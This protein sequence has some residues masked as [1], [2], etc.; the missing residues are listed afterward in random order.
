MKVRDVMTTPVVTVREEATLEEVARLMLERNIGGIPVVKADG[1]LAGIVTESDFSAKK[2]PVPFSLL[3][4]PS[5]LGHWLQDSVERT[6]R[7]ARTIEAK[8]VMTANV[9]TVSEDDP[10]ELAVRR[11]CENDVHRLPVVRGGVPVG[12]VTRQD[13]LRLMLSDD[14]TQGRRA[15]PDVAAVAAGA[16]VPT[17]A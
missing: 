4:L 6:Y 5:V 15:T 3:R 7:E 14:V 16:A 10:I 17:G 2:E 9:V 13:L 8:R 11:M 12:I 1:R